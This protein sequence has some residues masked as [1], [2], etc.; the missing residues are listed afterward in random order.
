MCRGS[1]RTGQEMPPAVGMTDCRE[2]REAA[3]AVDLLHKRLFDCLPAQDCD[4][5]AAHWQ[6]HGPPPDPVAARSA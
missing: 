4:P 6:G 3:L 2:G 1:P 5:I